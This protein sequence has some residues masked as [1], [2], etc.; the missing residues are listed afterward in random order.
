VSIGPLHEHWLA[1]HR[2]V[3]AGRGFVDEQLEGPF[4]SWIHAHRIEPLG[5]DRSRLTDSIEY[6]LPFGA[7]GRLVGGGTVQRRLERTFAYRHAVLA[8]DLRRH[9]ER[10]GRSLR[11]AV[12]GTSGSTW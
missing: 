11:V 7:L 5:P 8:D 10:G 9:A 4:R 1:V 12:T 3:T 6:T 2:D